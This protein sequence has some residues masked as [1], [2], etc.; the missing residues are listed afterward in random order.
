MIP[1]FLQCVITHVL[2]GEDLGGFV[3]KQV[4]VQVALIMPN[5]L[6]VVGLVDH[7]CFMAGLGEPVNLWH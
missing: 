1:D 2:R 7:Y 3:V 6:D 5:G 4:L